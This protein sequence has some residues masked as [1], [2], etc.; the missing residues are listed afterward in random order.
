[1]DLG[2][3]AVAAS[4]PEIRV[5]L[6]DGTVTIRPIAGTRR[7]GATPEEDR[8]L[9]DD[10]LNDPKELAEH[11]M[12]LDL[13]RNDVGRVSEVGSVKVT[14]RMMVEF[15]SHVMHIVS[16]VEGRLRDGLQSMDA[17]IAGFPAG[18]V[19]GA[20]KVRAMEIIDELE[21]DQRGIYAGAIGYFGA[22]GS[23]DTC[24]ALR[25]A[26]VTEG[27]MYVQAGAG[28]VADSDPESEHQECHNKARAL[29]RAAE[30]AI[31]FALSRGN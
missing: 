12:L 7:R 1:L 3:Y 16:N 17:L 9:A 8:A 21:P 14:E 18:T 28:I 2:G 31:D 26:V 15:Y 29:I 10:L 6:R 19:S 11:L 27:T 24:I 5:R 25:T 20:P 13:G 22:N 30:E 23:M 4:S